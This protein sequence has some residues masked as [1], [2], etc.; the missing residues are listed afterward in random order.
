M[1]AL[2]SYIDASFVYGNDENETK[3]LRTNDG[4]G[5]HIPDQLRTYVYM[6]M[7]IKKLNPYTMKHYI[8]TTSH[9][10]EGVRPKPQK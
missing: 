5:K 8:M 6:N 4:T 10:Q 2:T 1:D 9:S 7:E 3:S